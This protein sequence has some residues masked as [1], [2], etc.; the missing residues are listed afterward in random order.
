MK[1]VMKFGLIACSLIVLL[2][3]LV[4]FEQEG[5]K[6]VQ[7]SIQN[8]AEEIDDQLNEIEKNL[9]DLEEK[10]KG[11]GAE[12]STTFEKEIGQIREKQATIKEKIEAGKAKG[13]EDWERLKIEID[14]ALAELEEWYRELARRFR[15]SEREV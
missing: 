1:K 11:K 5:D 2:L 8:Y 14:K 6:A 7:S 12:L 15:S 9:K 13:K 3:L 10:I 4:S